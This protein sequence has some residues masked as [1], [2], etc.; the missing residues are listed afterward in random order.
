M[1]NNVIAKITNCI[2]MYTKPLA[3]LKLSQ[4]FANISLFLMYPGLFFYQSAI[5][6]DWI[7]PVIFGGWGVLMV[8]LC[9][10]LISLYFAKTIHITRKV[11]AIECMFFTF[12]IFTLMASIVYFLREIPTN[13]SANLFYWNVAGVLSNLTVFFAFRMA[14]IERKLL[15]FL[16]RS[17]AVAII[18]IVFANTDFQALYFAFIKVE[19]LYTYQGFARSMLIVF[20]IT[21]FSIRGGLFV[22]LCYLLF[23]FVL[24]LNQSRTELILFI[25]SV[26]AVMTL[27]LQYPRN[28][29][30]SSVLF[31]LTLLTITVIWALL[32]YNLLTP[33]GLPYIRLLA[34]AD[35]MTDGSYLERLKQTIFAL[36]IIKHSPLF[37][38]YGGYVSALGQGSYSHNLLSVWV[39]LGLLGIL[40]YSSTLALVAYEVC[41]IKVKSQNL[42]LL[43]F[44]GAVGMSA[45][46]AHLVSYTYVSVLLAAAIGLMGQVKDLQNV[47]HSS[48]T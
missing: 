11:F 27:T 39:N 5:G 43:Y 25:F 38:D 20:L 4:N 17:S 33:N 9:P 36:E 30:A 15:I 40:L 1:I 41:K 8:I 6:L 12:L 14:N 45:V 42:I 13:I 2:L 7:P 48:L 32:K 46:I 47:E 21:C 16:M 31:C 22:F 26:P 19:Y 3:S 29:I 10:C 34:L 18:L 44:A 23:A 35:P 24:L 28:L 37:G